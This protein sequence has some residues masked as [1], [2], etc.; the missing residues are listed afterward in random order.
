MLP[1]QA[2][3]SRRLA[4]Q[5][6]RQIID[7]PRQPRSGVGFGKVFLEGEEKCLLHDVRRI[8]LGEPV[9]PGRAPNQRSEERPVESL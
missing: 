2:T 1:E 4:L 7:D 9:P 5:A 8:R 3:P 6:D